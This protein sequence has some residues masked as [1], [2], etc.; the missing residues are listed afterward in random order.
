MLATLGAIGQF[1]GGIHI[2]TKGDGEER[3][4][5]FGPYE[6]MVVRYLA[7]QQARIGRYIQADTLAMTAA[8]RPT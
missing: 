4:E 3:H 1:D 8:Q 7:P 6:G 2:R 5:L